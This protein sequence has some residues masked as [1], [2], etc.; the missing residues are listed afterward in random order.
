M[1]DRFTNEIWEEFRRAFPVGAVVTVTTDRTFGVII[2]G[3]DETE[4]ASRILGYVTDGLD[5]PRRVVLSPAEV[6]E[7]ISLALYEEPRALKLG[8]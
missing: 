4:R 1:L 5:V 3:R 6:V 7:L 2:D 8:R